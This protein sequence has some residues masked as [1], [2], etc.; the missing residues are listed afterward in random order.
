MEQQA[1]LLLYQQQLQT[2][3]M[4]IIQN[5]GK[6]EVR[7]PGCRGVSIRAERS[8]SCIAYRAEGGASWLFAFA[9]RAVRGCAAVCH[10]KCGTHSVRCADVLRIWFGVMPN[11]RGNSASRGV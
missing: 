9:A 3:E 6:T 1:Q 11:S 2:V 10:S 5:P 4:Q 8:M 7:V